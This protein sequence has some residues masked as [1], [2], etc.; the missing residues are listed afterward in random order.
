MVT[1]L[2]DK[3]QKPVP[4]IIEILAIEFNN[5]VFEEF[6]EEA[7]L[8]IERRIVSWW[9][10]TWGNLPVNGNVD[11]PRHRNYRQDVDPEIINS[12]FKPK[13]QSE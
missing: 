12:I 8:E 4:E 3:F 7:P 1:D 9:M 11:D 5:D 10:T 6:E 2:S 13:P